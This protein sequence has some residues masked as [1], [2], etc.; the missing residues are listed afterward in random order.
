M[1]E[2]L[3]IIIVVIISWFWQDSIAKREIAIYAGR[4]LASR[5]SLQLLDESVA[6]NKIRFGRDGHGRM[7]I[8][9]LYDFEVSADGHTRLSCHLQLLGKQLQSWDIPPYIKPVH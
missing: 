6:C 5:C 8:I 9:R 2:I 1:F 7:Q 3:L 4:D